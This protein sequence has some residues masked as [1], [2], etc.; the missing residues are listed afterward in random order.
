[1]RFIPQTELDTMAMLETLGLSSIDELVAHIPARLRASATIDLP[2][3]LSEQE[4][5]AELSIL[6]TRNRGAREFLSFLGGGSYR[7]YVPSAVRAVTAR[8]EFA[9]AYTPYQPEASQ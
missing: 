5:V 4:L 8:A 6:S 2:P 9:T 1:M 3:G 7:H